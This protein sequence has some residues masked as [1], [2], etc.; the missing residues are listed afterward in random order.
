MERFLKAEEFKRLTQVLNEVEREAEIHINSIRAIRL[1]I[2]TRRRIG[3]TLELK[4]EYIDIENKRAVLP[5]SK[6][7]MK[8]VYLSGPALEMIRSVPTVE[9]NPYILTGRFNPG[10]YKRIRHH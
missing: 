6:T 2:F 5:D 9:D 8:T 10:H 3:E 7:G 1:L 4:W